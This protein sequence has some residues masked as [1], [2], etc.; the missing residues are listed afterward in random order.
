[1]EEACAAAM[2]ATPISQ[3][4]RTDANHSTG[5][6]NGK[7]RMTADHLV[8][9]LAWM[10][11]DVCKIS[12]KCRDPWDESKDAEI[13]PEQWAELEMRVQVLFAMNRAAREAKE[14]RNVKRKRGNRA[15]SYGVATS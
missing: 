2:P 4:A 5:K 9:T 13:T 7:A 1:M 11:E 10:I 12:I 14:V 15:N 3:R 8:Q 6:R